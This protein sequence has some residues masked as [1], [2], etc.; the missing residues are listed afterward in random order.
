MDGREPGMR[1]PLP[2]WEIDGHSVLVRPA[3]PE[4]SE[5]DRYHLEIDGLVC[6]W[7]VSPR[8]PAAVWRLERLDGRLVAAVSGGADRLEA[9][10]S[11]PSRRGCCHPRPSQTRT[12]R[13]PASGSS[14]ESFAPDGLVMDDPGRWQ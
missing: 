3:R 1:A 10:D 9:L 14:G 8:H 5:R 4:R 6:G 7:V 11:L 2:R 13:F 12:C